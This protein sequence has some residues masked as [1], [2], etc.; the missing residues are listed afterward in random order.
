MQ[1]NKLKNI[2]RNFGYIND[3]H[4]FGDSGPDTWMAGNIVLIKKNEYDNRMYE[5]GIS[6]KNIQ[7][8]FLKI[9][10]SPIVSA[11][12]FNIGKKKKGNDGNM[13]IVVCNKNKIK[14]WKKILKK[15]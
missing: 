8:N 2:V 13:W 3:K 12:K 10:P 7:F 4:L 6:T 1:Q 15:P 11:K 9:R 14:R 5:F